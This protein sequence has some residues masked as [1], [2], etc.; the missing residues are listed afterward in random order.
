MDFD[1]RNF[2]GNTSWTITCQHSSPNASDFTSSS[3]VNVGPA[4]AGYSWG[5]Y[6]V[7]DKALVGNARIKLV[8]G[9][10]TVLSPWV[11]W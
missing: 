4:G 9:G 10:Q 1:I 11:A 8:R 6:C 7:F 3:P 5:G 2:P